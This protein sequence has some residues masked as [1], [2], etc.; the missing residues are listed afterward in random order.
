MAWPLNHSQQCMITVHVVYDKAVFITN[1]E[2]HHKTG[3]RANV[4]CQVEQP[5]I[6]M[7]VLGSSSVEDQAAVIP[8]RIECLS[9]LANPVVTT[10]GWYLMNTHNYYRYTS[11]LYVISLEIILQ[12][13]LRYT[14]RW[15][16]S[17][18]RVWHS[19]W[20]DRRS[21]SCLTT[22]NTVTLR[23]RVTSNSRTRW[24]VKH[25]EL[26]RT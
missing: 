22:I 10:N 17:M 9:D 1:E 23:A 6:Y 3:K 4:Q 2:Y 24:Y 19:C 26:T 11:I 12:L 5:E 18:W 21:T 25:W 8:D 7:L 15:P 16:L 20:H 14:A 13:I